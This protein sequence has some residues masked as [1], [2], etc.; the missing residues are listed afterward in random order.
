ME[1]ATKKPIVSESPP[2]MYVVRKVNELPKESMKTSEDINEKKDDDP[3][4]HWLIPP[5][6]TSY[7]K[8]REHDCF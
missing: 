7:I 8:A 1:K 5:Q 2:K 6:R 4:R 3:F